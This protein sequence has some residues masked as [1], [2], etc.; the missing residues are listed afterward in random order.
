MKNIKTLFVVVFIFFA[1]L[2]EAFHL[3][4]VGI[5][6]R[7]DPDRTHFFELI[8]MIRD[9]ANTKSDACPVGFSQEETIKAIWNSKK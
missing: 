7:D 4:Q 3:G 9:F 1:L 5:I 2:C 8:N 6:G